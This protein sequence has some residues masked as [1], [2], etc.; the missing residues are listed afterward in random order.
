MKQIQPP[1]NTQT[2]LS[3]QVTC[4]FFSK[5]FGGS[6]EFYPYLKMNPNWE[7]MTSSA[8]NQ[9]ITCMHLWNIIL[10]PMDKEKSQVIGKLYWSWRHLY[11]NSPQL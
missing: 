1:P 4:I 7:P 9:V 6:S 5:Y 11:D 10:R 3:K 2:T 8:R